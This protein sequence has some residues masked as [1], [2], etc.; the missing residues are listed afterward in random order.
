MEEI[1]ARV[2]AVELSLPAG[3]KSTARIIEKSQ[4]RVDAPPGTVDG[5][6]DVVRGM[7]VAPSMAA[8]AAVVQAFASNS[9]VVLTRVKNRYDDAAASA[10]GWRDLMLNFYLADDDAKHV[11]EVQ[12][13]HR[14]M[15][16]AREGLSGHSI[17][18]RVRNASELC[19]YMVSCIDRLGWKPDDASR[20][21]FSR[22][23]QIMLGL[24]TDFFEVCFN[25]E[26]AMIWFFK[27]ST[28]PPRIWYHAFFNCFFVISAI[29]YVAA[30]ITYWTLFFLY[31]FCQFCGMAANACYNKNKVDENQWRSYD[32]RVH[33]ADSSGVD[34]EARLKEA[35][36]DM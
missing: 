30:T 23:D 32:N 9:R 20:A 29:T 18:N 21:G 16:V 36:G 19:E 24:E 3:L 34:H 33:H 7:L 4:F 1:A 35:F 13:V 5:V 11:C 6:F 10:G 12:V 26:L 17:Y 22:K 8:V 31:K 2:P 15:L 25:F 28:K 14:Q 27:A